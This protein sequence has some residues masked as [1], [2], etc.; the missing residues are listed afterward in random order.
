MSAIAKHNEEINEKVEE[1][2]DIYEGR[3]EIE[4]SETF[5]QF[6]KYYYSQ[7]CNR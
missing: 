6:Y 4:R 1:R 3:F 5:I 2:R 7:M